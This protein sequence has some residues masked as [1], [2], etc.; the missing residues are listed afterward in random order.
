MDNKF[1][2]DTL[3]TCVDKIKFLDVIHVGNKKIPIAPLLPYISTDTLSTCMNKCCLTQVK[4]TCNLFNVAIGL[5]EYDCPDDYK[6]RMVDLFLN[7][8]IINAY[9]SKNK[10]QLVRLLIHLIIRR[11]YCWDDIVKWF[12]MIQ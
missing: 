10:K 8:K 6:I 3:I 1:Y 12:T 4:D 9:E 5:D 2:K 11:E 7:E